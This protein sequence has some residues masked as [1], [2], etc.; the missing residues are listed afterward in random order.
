LADDERLMVEMASGVN[1]ALCYDGRL[2]KVLGRRLGKGSKVVIVLCG[3]SNVTV[4]MLMK[5]RQEFGGVE[6]DS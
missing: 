3:G 4:D 6:T 1:V 2:D 5:W